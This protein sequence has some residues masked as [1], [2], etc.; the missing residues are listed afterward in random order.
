MFP[1]ELHEDA[2]I[3]EAE[4]SAVVV[5][6]GEFQSPLG[7][8]VAKRQKVK[9]LAVRDHAIEVEHDGFQQS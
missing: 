4:V 3:V 5:G 2:D 6:L 8:H 1:S 7:E 9:R